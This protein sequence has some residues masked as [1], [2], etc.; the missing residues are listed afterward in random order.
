MRLITELA[1]L[2]NQYIARHEPWKLARVPE[3]H[4]EMQ[5]IC[6]QGINLFRVLA[7]YLQPILPGMA[8]RSRDFLNVG[9]FTWDGI[10][11]PLL[12][13]EIG[14]FQPL[15]KRMEKK[16]LEALVEASKSEADADDGEAASTEDNTISIDEFA[17]V[18]LKVASVVAAE[19]VDGADKLLR[20]TVDLGDERR[21]VFAGIKAAYPQ[22]ESLVGRLVVVVANLAPREMRFG[23][24]EGM[25]LAA[26]PGGEDIFLIGP[27][28]GAQPGMDVR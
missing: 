26:G 3:R 7:I 9:P 12:G 2:A 6:S 24:S 8:E 15:F 20:L 5:A 23:T 11:K 13:H 21:Q 27:D 28:S 16:D 4:D 18:E 1:D 25:V 14:R 19:H 17:K 22:P 10:D